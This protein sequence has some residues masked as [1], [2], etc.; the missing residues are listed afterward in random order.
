MTG[1]IKEVVGL[2]LD[3]DETGLG[4]TKGLMSVDGRRG[5]VILST[6]FSLRTALLSL[7]LFLSPTLRMA[8][9]SLS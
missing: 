9:S 7:L 8:V 1:S 6:L 4:D 5:Q 3:L 2:E